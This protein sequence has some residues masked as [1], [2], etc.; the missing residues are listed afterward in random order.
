MKLKIKSFE[1]E[2]WKKINKM[3]CA[4][5]M[6]DLTDYNYYGYEI[7][8]QAKEVEE[9]KTGIEKKFEELEDISYDL[10]NGIISED[11]ALEFMEF[12][13]YDFE[14]LIASNE[15]LNELLGKFDEG[16]RYLK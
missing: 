13:E 11:D 8:S 12:L 1:N 4:C 16:R 3:H 15:T 9:L 6:L 10:E 2:M 7:A 14:Y 5:D